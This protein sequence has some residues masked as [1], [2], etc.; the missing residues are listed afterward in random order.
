MFCVNFFLGWV[1]LVD[2]LCVVIYFLFC[3]EGICIKGGGG[4][5]VW[6]CMVK[7]FGGV[8]FCWG[9][10]LVWL[11]MWL[12]EDSGRFCGCIG[13]VIGGMWFFDDV[14]FKEK[15]RRLRNW[16]I[17]YSIKVKFFFLGIFIFGIFLFRSINWSFCW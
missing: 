3:E 11:M 5:R 12:L 10:K 9:C 2:N 13:F 8:V 7:L 14:G 4:F 15:M 6:G 16:I 1:V 17:C